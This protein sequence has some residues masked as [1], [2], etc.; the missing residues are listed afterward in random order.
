[1][2]LLLGIIIVLLLWSPVGNY[3]GTIS[4]HT[5]ALQGHEKRLVNIEQ[6]LSNQKVPD[7]TPSADNSKSRRH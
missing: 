5:L 6:Y 4:Q 1:M 3:F 2:Q 7:A